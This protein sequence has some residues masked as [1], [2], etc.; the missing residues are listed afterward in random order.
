MTRDI[1][2]TINQIVSAENRNK[3]FA[4]LNKKYTYGEL[5]IDI[6]KTVNIIEESGINHGDKI[7]ISSLNDYAVSILFL[8]CLRGGYVAVPFDPNHTFDQ[9]ARLFDF[10]D[11][12]ALFLDQD[13]IE[14]WSIQ[15]I[16]QKKVVIPIESSIRRKGSLFKKMLRIEKPKEKETSFFSLLSN[17][18][19]SLLEQKVKQ[20]DTAYLLFTSGSTSQP[21]AVQINHKALFAN[22]STLNNVYRL[23]E[24]SNIFNILTLYHTDGLIQGPL[25]AATNL[26]TWV[27]PF[28]FNVDKIQHIF[29]GIYKYKISH[30]I[31]VPTI[32]KFLEKFSEGFENSLQTTNFKYIISSASPLDASFWKSF[33]DKFKTII[34]N[35]YGLTETVVGA[36]YSGPDQDTLKYGSV[37]KPKDCI[38]KIIDE[39][40]QS[41]G[42]GEKG[43]LCI[44]GSNLLTKYFRNEKA[45]AATIID[46]WFHTGDIGLYDND[47]FYFIEGRKNNLII[48]GGINIQPEEVNEVISRH[49]MIL[50]SACF[51]VPDPIFGEILVAAVVPSTNIEFEKDKLIQYCKDH[52]QAIK[53]P[54]SF[55]TIDE[56]PKTISGK[57]QYTELR[58]LHKTDVVTHNAEAHHS[59]IAIIIGAAS[60]AFKLPNNKIN[61]KISNSMN[62]EGWDSLAHLIFITNLEKIFN[63]RFSTKE[64]MNMTSIE[65]ADKTIR[66]KLKP[67]NV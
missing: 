54:S 10:V 34:I 63:I 22:L 24:E 33:E 55:F 36:S 57:I 51:G 37:G 1:Y 16:E 5:G 13:L 6:K 45:T 35:N 50:D 49:S 61:P 29:D 67:S 64:I 52:L 32:L 60:D 48:S 62:T 47:G 59:R 7:I 20:E 46:G 15:Q 12:D 23:Q 21:K 11:P 41:L 27:H 30:F 18:E 17:A 38:F 65:A 25:L 14:K 56:I 2:S 42:P 43:E 44:K 31:V 66:N 39:N 4:Y 8:S 40:G 3:V 28:D 9:S 26:A 53:V 58:N 19:E